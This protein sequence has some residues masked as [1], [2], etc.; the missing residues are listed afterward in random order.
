MKTNLKKLLASFLAFIMVLA[1]T[2]FANAEAGEEETSTPRIPEESDAAQVK[3]NNVE[4]GSTVKAYRIVMPKYGE[5]GKGFLGFESLKINNKTIIEDIEK[6]KKSEIEEIANTIKKDEKEKAESINIDSVTFE[7][8]ESTTSSQGYEK[9]STYTANLHAGLWVILVTSA[10]NAITSY[11]P[12]VAGVYYTVDNEITTAPL[13]DAN[14][15]WNIEGTDDVYAKKLFEPP[16]EKNIIENSGEKSEEKKKGSSAKKGEL[17]EFEIKTKLPEY[18]KQFENPTFEIKDELSAGIDLDQTSVKVYAGTEPKDINLLKAKEDYQIDKDERHFSINFTSNYIQNQKRTISDI[19]V[20][21]KAKLNNKAGKN[22]DA[23]TNTATLNY[24]YDPHNPNTKDDKTATTYLYTFDIDGYPSYIHKGEANDEDK[25]EVKFPEKTTKEI[26]KSGVGDDENGLGNAIFTLTD[27]N[28]KTSV[29]VTSSNDQ[30]NKG[31]LHFE[32]LSAGSYI[33]N[34]K[35][36]PRGYTLNGEKY[37]INISERY[38]DDGRLKYYCINVNGRPSSYEV[39][40]K[41]GKMLPITINVNSTEIKNTKTQELPSTGGIGTF[42]FTLV[43]V[44]LM[45]VAVVA[46]KKHRQESSN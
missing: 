21:Y 43:G 29:D 37:K 19:L 23:N 35:S 20:R 30:E 1:M 2:P 6:P 31:K 42:V 18:S 36:A 17:V 40:Y 9:D 27:N 8:G 38:Q 7:E 26:W 46:T 12:M 39:I 41:D 10:D 33:L 3:V 16:L 4:S 45:V 25:P 44:A 28:T 22:F 24:S 32:D 5:N 34:E 13:I 14:S 11:N 15:D